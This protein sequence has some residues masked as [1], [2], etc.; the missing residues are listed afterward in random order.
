MPIRTKRPLSKDKG[1]FSILW[2]V[3]GRLSEWIVGVSKLE[4]RGFYGIETDIA[5]SLTDENPTGSIFGDHLGHSHGFYE[6]ADTFK[7][8]KLQVTLNY[9]LYFAAELAST[10]A[11][12]YLYQS[13][14][15][16][17]F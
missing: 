6:V 2:R 10:V 12:F 17:V 8:R 7:E 13:K 4:E 11:R 16:C 15:V 9:F 14:N 3:L 5:V 1:L